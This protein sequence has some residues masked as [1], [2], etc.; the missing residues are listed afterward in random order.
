MRKVVLFIA[1]SVDGYIA[2]EQHNVDWL[3]GHSDDENLD[4]YSTFIQGVDTVVM[5]WKTYEQIITQLSPEQWVYPNLTSYV[6]THQSA[7]ST[8]NIVFTDTAPARL[9]EQLKTEQG[10]AIWIC[11]GATIAQQLIQANLIDEYYLS[12][13]PTILGKGIR[14]FDE[15]DVAIPLKLVHSQSYNG[16]TELVYQRRE[17]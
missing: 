12:I 4:T 3:T 10:K 1:M 9:V 7:Q 5:G 14:L 17:N 11:G 2:D 8:E 13:I 15:T 16:I 6:I